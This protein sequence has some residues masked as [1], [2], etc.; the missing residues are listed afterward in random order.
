M[1]FVSERIERE[2][3][4]A[5][6]NELGF[7]DMFGEPLKPYWWAIDREREIILV[8]RGGGSFDVPIGYGLYIKG[9]I[10][11]ME[12]SKFTDE[13]DFDNLKVN[14]HIKK[15]MV[16]SKLIQKGYDKKVIRTIIEQAF[17]GLGTT[18]VK[19]TRIAEVSVRILS[20]L[21]II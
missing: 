18:G 1:A 3:D 10:V 2:E 11:E 7:T 19:R 6:F 17:H 8:P 15:T 21:E 13:E 16:P 14:W 9:I 20:E 4:K 12:V 5:Y